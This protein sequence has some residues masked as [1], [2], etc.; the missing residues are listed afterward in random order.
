MQQVQAYTCQGQS[1]GPSPAHHSRCCSGVYA[2]SL[3]WCLL[4]L[5]GGWAAGNLLFRMDPQS[6]SV[7]E[8]V[9]TDAGSLD[10]FEYTRTPAVAKRAAKT[11]ELPDGMT[12]R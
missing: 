6:R 1:S 9:L 11:Y 4:L 12:G 8:V 7:V 5:H 2:C 3:I 10:R